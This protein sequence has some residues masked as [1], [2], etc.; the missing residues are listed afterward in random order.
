MNPL[1]HTIVFALRIYRWVISPAKT[2]FFG[3]LGRCRFTP[4]CSQYALTAVQRYGAA[5]GG[6]LAARRLCRCHPWGDCGHDPVPTAEDPNFSNLPELTGEHRE[7]PG[8]APTG[9]LAAGQY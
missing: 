3:P 7:A 5:R 2:L 1:S 9:R 6:W 8:L 4:S